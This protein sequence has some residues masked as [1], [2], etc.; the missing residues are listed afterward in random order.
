MVSYTG[1]IFESPQDFK[2]LEYTVLGPVSLN[3]KETLHLGQY[4]P[5]SL[6]QSQSSGSTKPSIDSASE[7]KGVKP[8]L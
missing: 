3:E 6:S 8:H 4:S 5:F 1:L 7:T 2:S